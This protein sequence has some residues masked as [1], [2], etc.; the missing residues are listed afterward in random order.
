MLVSQKVLRF[1]GLFLAA[2][3][4]AVVFASGG[5]AQSSSGLVKIGA[6]IAI[7]LGAAGAATGQGRAASSALEG[8]A[9]NPASRGDV[10]VPMILALVFMEFQALLAFV[11]AFMILG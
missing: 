6:A 10:F 7:G 4:S 11:V 8:I 2:S 9:R 3:C 5:D 1:I